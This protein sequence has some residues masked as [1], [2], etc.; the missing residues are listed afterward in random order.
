MKLGALLKR[1]YLNKRRGLERV[2]QE[3]L[4]V[5]HFITDQGSGKFLQ[6]LMKLPK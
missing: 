3:V 2:A 6:K 1:G 5:R 4:L